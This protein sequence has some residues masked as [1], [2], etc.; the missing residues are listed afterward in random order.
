M[1]ARRNLRWLAPTI[2]A[3]GIAIGRLAEGSNENDHLNPVRSDLETGYRKFL[4][5]FLFITPGD[6][7][8]IVRL[9]SAASD[10]ESAISISSR[11]TGVVF[12]ITYTKA[13][14]NIWCAASE[15]DGGFARRPTLDVR[16]RD[17][18]L[19]RS[20]A[21]LIATKIRRAIERRAPIVKMGRIPIDGTEIMFSTTDQN[22]K[23][24][25]AMLDPIAEGRRSYALRRLEDLL[26]RYCEAE[27]AARG[28][29]QQDIEVE[30]KAVGEESR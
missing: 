7:L 5:D 10:G 1:T 27:P 11:S 28:K 30:A 18:T 25:T 19:L 8:R 3:I 13:N 16:R 9:P 22:G 21:E 29:L 15:L 14:R 23:E 17:A 26:R 4:A 6:V 24:F 20:T 2:F 12:D